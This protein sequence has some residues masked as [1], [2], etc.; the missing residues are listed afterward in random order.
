MTLKELFNRR[1]SLRTRLFL[2]MILLVFLAC[3]LILV[4]TYIQYQTEADDYNLFR[5]DRKEQ[6]IQ[7]Q[8][9][10]LV[11]KHDLEEASD[12][13]WASYVKD[14]RSITKIHKV[15]FSIFSL[16]GDSLFVSFT[17]LKIIAN[18]YKVDSSLVAKVFQKS[19]TRY[20]EE[21]NDEIGKFQSSYSLLK[22]EN[23]TPYAI[24]FFPY[25]EDVSFSENELNKFLQRLYQVYLIML[26][27][28][29]FF[30]YFISRYVTRSL[31][32]LRQM[33]GQTGFLT[34]N[35]KIHLDNA[36]REIEGLVN[37]YNNMIDDLEKSAE[38]LAKTE[39]EQAWQEMARQVAHEIKNPLTPMR[40]TVQSFQRRLDPN[41][42]ELREKIDEFSSMLITQIDTMSQVAN[43]FSDYAT[44]PKAQLQEDNIVKLTRRATDVFEQENVE[45]KTTIKSQYVLL[46]RTQ[47]IRVMTNLIQ[48]GIQSVPTE[49]APKI[50]VQIKIQADWVVITV[51]DNGNGIATENKDKIFE[52]KFTTKTK[53]MGLGLGIVKNIIT[54]H[55]GEISFTSKEGTGTTFKV[56]I[57]LI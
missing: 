8:L 43:A 35:K 41:D 19:G 7:R 38:L 14:L 4:A 42:P 52:P 15:E 30:A 12:S 57:P 44:L 17:P 18:N 45:F 47:W 20:L 23:G 16:E 24:L 34:R 27:V 49:K 2:S 25:F 40:L 51:K 48:N 28:A 1:L 3:M 22:N 9:N 54:S 31:E 6:Q 11:D 5:L 29:I 46:D 33:I 39:R 56:K 37:S 26:V 32:K 36:T 50:K 21:S 10:Y 53:G 55:N 13:V